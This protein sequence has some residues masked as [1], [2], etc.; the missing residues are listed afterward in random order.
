MNK[1]INLLV[2]PP[3]FIPELEDLP[4]DDQTWQEERDMNQEEKD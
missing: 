2:L 1:Q 4:E 3:S